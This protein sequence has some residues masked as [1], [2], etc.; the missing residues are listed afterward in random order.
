MEVRKKNNL[1]YGVGGGAL[2]LGLLG[3]LFYN[4]QRLKNRQQVKEYEL[5]KA[6]VKI[7]TQNRLQ[8]QR[9]RISRD[10]HDNIGSQLTF[11]TSSLDNLK[12]G[13][14]DEEV[15][16]KE[17]LTEI[18]AFTK[19]TINE[20]RDTIW[21][22]NKEKITF[23]DLEARLGNLLDQ[24]RTASSEINFDLI[25]SPEINR[26]DALSSVEGMNLY[27][28]IQEAINNAIKYAEANH[29][30]VTLSRNRTGEIHDQR[31][32]K[33]INQTNLEAAIVDNG[34]GFNTESPELGN[35]L[36]NMKKRINEIQGEIDIASSIGKGT[37]VKLRFPIAINTANDV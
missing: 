25:I 36:T 8:E 19:T 10:L 1:I 14:K 20:L 27:R 16:T 30:T 6:L 35:G 9:L 12:Y 15:K 17:K 7:E 23:E 22:M 4:Q 32:N 13:M 34:K 5:E 29:I 21:A 24:A 11:I 33:V 3:Y 18:G 26:E 31:E 2:L 37:T 28:I